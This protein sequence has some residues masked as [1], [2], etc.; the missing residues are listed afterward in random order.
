MRRQ[1]H[2]LQIWNPES[3]TG[4]GVP[5]E[6]PKAAGYPQFPPSMSGPSPPAEPNVLCS[7]PCLKEQNSQS[8]EGG[9][10]ET[11]GDKGFSPVYFINNN[12]SYGVQINNPRA[13]LTLN[14]F[15]YSWRF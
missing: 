13:E 3:L 6:V 14:V 8:Q 9:S 1:I 12:A 10:K 7:L 11:H 4:E 2:Q 15:E 5:H